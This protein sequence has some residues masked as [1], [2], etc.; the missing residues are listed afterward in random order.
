MDLETNEQLVRWMEDQGLSPFTLLKL[1][2][3]PTPTSKSKGKAK[4]APSRVVMEWGLQDL[5]NET[6]R[7]EFMAWRVTAEEIEVFR[8]E[9]TLDPF[10]ECHTEL[11]Q[12]PGIDIRL[13]A[14]GSLE[15]RCGR[16]VIGEPVKRSR[17]GRPRP[18]HGEVNLDID[19]SKATW[20]LVRGWLGIPTDLE[21]VDQGTEKTVDA[22]TKPRAGD[23]IVFVD[24]AR[25][26]LVWVGVETNR[27]HIS[28]GKWASDE[29]WLGLW[30]RINSVPG[31]TRISSR[32][33]VCEPGAWPEQPPP[34]P[35]PQVWPNVFGVNCD[36]KDLTLDGL[37]QALQ[38]PAS[39][40]FVLDDDQAP[41]VA[42]SLTL[43]EAARHEGGEEVTG[44]FQSSSGKA[45][46]QCWADFREGSLRLTRE[47][48]CDD[49]TWLGVW[50]AHERLPTVT[51]IH[52]RTTT[53]PPDPW[54][55][56]PP[57]R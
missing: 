21:C 6:D 27:L 52:S 29:L 57:K 9:G 41:E 13:E 43:A 28:R 35:S 40:R 51:E 8:G 23:H 12:G 48:A 38:L 25:H 14:G 30:S 20:R 33:L 53:S 50:R 2:P 10:E 44:T 56:E 26:D 49:A 37:R 15:F 45:L 3:K 5:E 32:D 46:V 11:G 1:S 7:E 39:A 47:R 55:R 18:H 24:G 16:L 36:F 42:S 31:V 22:K 17:K 34:K 4:R 54:P 19:L